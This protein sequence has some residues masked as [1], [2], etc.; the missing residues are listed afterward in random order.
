MQCS[1]KMNKAKPYYYYLVSYFISMSLFAENITLELVTEH[2]PPYQIVSTENHITGFSTDIVNEMVKRSGYKE[3]LNAYSWARSYNLAQKKENTCIYSIIRLPEREA[4]FKW[5]GILTQT[6]N[7]IF[8]K[9][10]DLSVPFK[11]LDEAKNYTI[12]VIRNDAT[13][14]ILLSRGFEEGKNLY[15]INNTKSLFNLLL[16]RDSIDLIIA[17]DVTIG[18]RATLA[19]VNVN[20][21]SRLF[22]LACSLST[23]DKV[24]SKLKSAL[25]SIYQ[26]GFYQKVKHKWQNV[27]PELDRSLSSTYKMY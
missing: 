21:L 17:D 27:M 23:S 15:V 25:Q 8:G 26:D 5:V 9:K 11:S 4:L 24:I 7:V 6:N 2:L 22:Y 1:L 10:S 16:L 19:G 18:Y 12:A 20:E 3:E 14:F 13:H